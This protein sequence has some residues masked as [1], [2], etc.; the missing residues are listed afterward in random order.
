VLTLTLVDQ[1]NNTFYYAHVGDTRLY[2]LRGNSLIKVT[3]DHSFV[4]FLEDSGRLSEEEAMSHPKRNEIDKALGFN[5]QI[6]INTDY[7]ETGNSPFLPGDLLMLCSDGLTD[8][9]NNHTMASIL[10]SDKTL[11]EKGKD[12]IEAANEAGGKDNITVVLVQNTKKP[13]RQ[14][15]TKPI[16]RQSETPNPEPETVSKQEEPL[17]IEEPKESQRIQPKTQERLVEKKPIPQ[18]KKS[19]LVP[20]LFILCIL[21]LGGFLWQLLKNKKGTS[22]IDEETKTA[23]NVGEQQLLDSL[24]LA[25]G[26][27]L[28]LADTIYGKTI[29]ITDTISVAKDS[30]YVDGTGIVLKS[31]S[32]YFGP[33]MA[34]A[35]GA[36]NIILENMVFENFDIGILTDSR[37]IQLKNVRFINCRVPVQYGFHFPAN[38][39]VN[40]T[41]ADTVIFKTSSSPK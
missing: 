2:L 22:L 24:N 6:S 34:F 33:A 3:K 11:Q 20:V 19:M 21:L 14:K 39:Y 38:S 30:L 31:A 37:I 8:L 5:A 40:G 28:I 36:K 35:E 9:V 10:I 4:G 41:I 12:L 29:N 25:P 15:A 13:K 27:T 17:P 18:R 1:K 7:I 23:R 26:K 16:V 32:S